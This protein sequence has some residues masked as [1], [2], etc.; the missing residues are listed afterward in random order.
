MG[1]TTYTAAGERV[2]VLSLDGAEE[3]EAAEQDGVDLHLACLDGYARGC[4]GVL[5]M[6]RGRVILGGRLES[7][8]CETVILGLWK[9][10]DELGKKKVW[11]TL[12]G[13]EMEGLW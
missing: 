9:S 4:D 10:V 2:V 1:T 3:G 13:C 12:E 5:L 8:E 11:S 6:C 7:C